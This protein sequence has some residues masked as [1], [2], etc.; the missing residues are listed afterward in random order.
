[1]MIKI[2]MASGDYTYVTALPRLMTV[3]PEKHEITYTPKGTYKVVIYTGGD[4]QNFFIGG[5][6]TKEKAY[7]KLEEV[8]RAMYREIENMLSNFFIK[9]S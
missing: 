9:I 6:K 3:E 1:M 2:A 4:D 8:K 5:I 7:Q